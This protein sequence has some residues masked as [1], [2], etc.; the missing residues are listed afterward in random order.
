MAWGCIKGNIELDASL[1]IDHGNLF[2]KQA[3]EES[4]A[5]RR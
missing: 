3:S 2:I 5:G 1:S 4:A